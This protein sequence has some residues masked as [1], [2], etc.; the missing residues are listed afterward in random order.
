MTRAITEVI[1]WAIVSALV[2]LV[3]THPNGFAKDVSVVGT[4]G[5]NILQTF[6]GKDQPGQG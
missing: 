5:N 4:N 6:T 2:V 1:G 3:I